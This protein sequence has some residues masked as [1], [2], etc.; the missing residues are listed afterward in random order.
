MEGKGVLQEK[1]VGVESIG[2]YWEGS[3]P[4]V[5]ERRESSI[6]CCLENWEGVNLRGPGWG[7]QGSKGKGRDK[8][9]V[10]WRDVGREGN[11]EEQ[12]IGGNGCRM[13]D[14]DNE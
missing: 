14:G 2:R 12:R 6:K 8:G 11:K 9:L 7:E 10:G 1:W 3:S 5:G 4:G 13:R